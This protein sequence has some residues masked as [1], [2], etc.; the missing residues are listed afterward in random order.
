MAVF[1]G[2]NQLPNGQV[3]LAPNGADINAL[4]A[5]KHLLQ[6]S[7]LACV[8]KGTDD[9]KARIDDDGLD[10]AMRIAYWFFRIV[11][12]VDILIWPKFGIRH[13]WRKC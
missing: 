13:C 5:L 8:F 11:V 2:G 6:N 3:N 1:K 10:N 9:Y 7:G 12:C 4:A